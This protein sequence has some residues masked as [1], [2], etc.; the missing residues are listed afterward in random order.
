MPILLIGTTTYRSVD[1]EEMIKKL[2]VVRLGEAERTRLHGS[3]RARGGGGVLVPR[4]RAPFVD[5]ERC[6]NTRIRETV[7]NHHCHVV[8]MRC[9]DLTDTRGAGHGR[10]TLMISC[11]RRRRASSLLY[12]SSVDF[13]GCLQSIRIAPV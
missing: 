7:Y 13:S 4:V 1:D 10:R 5:D 8:P 12:S 3:G 11:L 2:Y 9:E 6:V